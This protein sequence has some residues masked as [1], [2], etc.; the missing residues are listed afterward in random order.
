MYLGFYI[1]TTFKWQKFVNIYIPIPKY[2]HYIPIQKVVYVLQMSHTWKLYKSWHRSSWNIVYFFFFF[3]FLYYKKSC[4]LFL[5]KFSFLIK[6]QMQPSVFTYTYN[7]I[8]KVLLDLV[9]GYYG[10]SFSVHFCNNL[11]GRYLHKYIFYK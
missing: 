2:I 6:Y 7:Y 8:V 4:V 5:I 11:Y 3:F 10:K 9:S 1:Y